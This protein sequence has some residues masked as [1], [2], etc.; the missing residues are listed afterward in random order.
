VARLGLGNSVSGAFSVEASTN[1]S[2]W[3]FLSP[4]TPLYLFADA[5]APAASERYYRLRY[6]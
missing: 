5:N 2:D 4:A 3:Q 1:L 6:P